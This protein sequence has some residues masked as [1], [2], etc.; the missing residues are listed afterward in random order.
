MVWRVGL[1]GKLEAADQRVSAGGEAV[2][3]QARTKGRRGSD[4]KDSVGSFDVTKTA[5]GQAFGLDAFKL[6]RDESFRADREAKGRRT[7]RI[8]DLER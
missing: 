7:R 4:A 6:D 3:L 1:A 8:H 5:L 2:D